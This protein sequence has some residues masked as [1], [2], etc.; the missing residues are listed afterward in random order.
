MHKAEFATSTLST[1]LI[2]VDCIGKMCSDSMETLGHADQAIEFARKYKIE[3]AEFEGLKHG[4]DQ[5][6]RE[7]VAEDG[8]YVDQMIDKINQLRLVVASQA[9]RLAEES[10]ELYERLFGDQKESAQLDL[11][12]SSSIGGTDVHAKGMVHQPGR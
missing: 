10:R 3:T 6:E 9:K 12:L 7:L 4:I 2:I 5:R 1:S 8:A 11:P